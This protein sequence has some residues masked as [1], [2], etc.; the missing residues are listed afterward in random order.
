[1]HRFLFIKFILLCGKLFAKLNTI[2]DIFSKKSVQTSISR[3]I[4]IY[5]VYYAMHWWYTHF[6]GRKLLRFQ[7][8][9][10]CTL[11]CVLHFSLNGAVWSCYCIR[12]WQQNSPQPFVI[13][14]IG[15]CPILSCNFFL[16]FC[17]LL[18][19]NSYY[20]RDVSIIIFFKDKIASS[21]RLADF[22]LPPHAYDWV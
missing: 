3:F 9:S 11:L 8:Y 18:T 7:V 6:H 1:M 13:L 2:C 16:N 20:E 12:K 15:P 22:C 10:E 5:N 19:C 4:N 17:S 21:S 14:A